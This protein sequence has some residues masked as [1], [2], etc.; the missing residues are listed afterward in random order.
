[1]AYFILMNDIISSLTV[2]ETGE[3]Y[4]GIMCPYCENTSRPYGLGRQSNNKIQLVRKCRFCKKL[5]WYWV[6]I[7]SALAPFGDQ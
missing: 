3:E 4:D 5:F 6:D 1:M 2:Q 7:K